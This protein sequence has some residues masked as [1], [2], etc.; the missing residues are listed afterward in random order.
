M[1]VRSSPNQ[2]RVA[3]VVS[4]SSMGMA[5]VTRTAATAWTRF[6]MEAEYANYLSA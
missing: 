6:N 5:M 3:S 2:I 1:S 4:G